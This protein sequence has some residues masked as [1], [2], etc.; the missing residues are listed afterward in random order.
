MTMPS[1]PLI[2]QEV[3]FLFWWVPI[4]ISMNLMIPGPLSI[5]QTTNQMFFQLRL[6]SHNSKKFQMNGREIGKS[7]VCS[8]ENWCYTAI[9]TMKFF[10]SVLLKPRYVSSTWSHFLVIQCASSQGFEGFLKSWKRL[11]FDLAC[12]EASKEM[13]KGHFKG[14]NMRK[15]VGTM[16]HINGLME[17]PPSRS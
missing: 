9:P 15:M 17:N 12:N 8:L 10:L 7:V 1:T 14:E 5:S 2:L 3:M 4:V 11:A 13:I 16:L 6:G